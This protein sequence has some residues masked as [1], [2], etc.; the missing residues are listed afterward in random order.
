MIR[1]V[2][3]KEIPQVADMFIEF[4]FELKV[5]SGDSYF[6]FDQIVKVDIINYLVDFLNCDTGV[7]YCSTD[8]RDQIAGFIVGMEKDCFLPLSKVKKIGYIEALYVKNAFR[9]KGIAK[10]LEEMLLNYFRGRELEYIELNLLTNNDQAK[11]FWSYR[12][13]SAFREQYRKHL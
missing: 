13:Y 1:A 7:I 4:M 2:D 9:R 5:V 3:S 8:N 11:G 12:D 6:D 10:E